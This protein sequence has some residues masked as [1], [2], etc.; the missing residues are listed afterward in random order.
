MTTTDDGKAPPAGGGQDDKGKGGG[1]GDYG[2]PPTMGD[3]RSMVAETV[4]SALKPFMDKL[5]GG[6]GG[7]QPP[8][9]TP[10]TGTDTGQPADIAGMVDAA[11]AK[12]LGDRDKKAGD[13]AHAKQH[14]DLAAAAAE[15]RPVERPRR[16]RWLGNIYDK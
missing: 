1:E 9:D 15:R 16:S 11:L 6:Q 4:E 3:L 13:D 2:K 7:G 12:V 5:G 10:K 14:E 8:K